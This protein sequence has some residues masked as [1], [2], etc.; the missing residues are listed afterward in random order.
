[1]I[2][3]YYKFEKK[4]IDTTHYVSKQQLNTKYNIKD[5]LILKILDKTRM[6][7]GKRLANWI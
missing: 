1:M 4:Y 7:I 5:K 2:R 3:I 6:N